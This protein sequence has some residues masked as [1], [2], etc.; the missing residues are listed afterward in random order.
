MNTLTFK[1]ENW[2]KD[3]VEVTVKSETEFSVQGYDFKIGETKVNDIGDGF[4]FEFTDVYSLEHSKTEPSYVVTR[5]L[6]DSKYAERDYTT[7]EGDIRRSG[8]SIQE[9][10]AKIVA[11]CY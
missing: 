7:S 10:I 3:E 5:D 8:K 2:I 6:S 9:V 11:M 4:V 1:A